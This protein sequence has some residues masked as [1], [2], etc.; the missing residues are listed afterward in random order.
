M[1]DFV[2]VHLITGAVHITLVNLKHFEEQVPAGCFLRTHRSFLV[3]KA[4]ISVVSADEVRLGP[5]LAVPLGQSFREDVLA[6]V[7]Q[8]RLV[9]RHPAGGK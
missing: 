2:K 4:H 1:R 8:Q 3:N 9:S 5:T 6:Q 7:V